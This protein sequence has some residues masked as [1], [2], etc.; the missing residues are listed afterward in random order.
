MPIKQYN[1][2]TS[3]E[4]NDSDITVEPKKRRRSRKFKHKKK[5]KKPHWSQKQKDE[6]LKVYVSLLESGS[7]TL[8]ASKAAGAPISTINR[9]LAKRKTEQP[10]PSSRWAEPESIDCAIETLSSNSNCRLSRLE[11]LFKLVAWLRWPNQPNQ[12]PSA[13][14]FCIISYLRQSSTAQTLAELKDSERKLIESHLRLDVLGQVYSENYLDMPLFSDHCIDDQ[15]YDE[16][17]AIADIVRFM[18]AYEQKSYPNGGKAT[19]RKAHV[20]LSY[21]I[22]KYKWAISKATFWKFWLENGSAGPFHYVRS[23]SFAAE[24]IPDPCQ[25]DF[26]NRVDYCANNIGEIRKYLSHCRW[27]VEALAVHLND[28]SKKS[29]RFPRFPAS[30]ETESLDPLPLS[31]LIFDLIKI[32]KLPEYDDITDA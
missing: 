14:A 28:R 7:S 19:L 27:A 11:A 15:P 1:N 12:H 2:D 32:G 9:W 6:C 18:L 29:V 24:L 13:I 23:Y 16:Y 5:S 17:D 21:G 3:G 8:I 30:L 4:S 31:P 10:P 22:C 26:A 25:I 20:G